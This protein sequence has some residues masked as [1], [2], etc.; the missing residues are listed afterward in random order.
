[1]ADIPMDGKGAYVYEAVDI[2]NYDGDSFRCVLRKRWDF[3]FHIHV[4]QEYAIAVRIKGVDTPELRDNRKDWKAAGFLARDR[5]REWLKVRQPGGAVR[6]ISM[7]KPDKYGRALGDFESAVGERLSEYLLHERLGV[8]YQGQ[9]KADV[10]KA[11]EG[12][13]GWLKLQ[14]LI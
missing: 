7:D 8:P 9:N 3:G 13:I 2:T 11:H 14:G 6:F 10:E 12:N 1:M 5:A 4:T